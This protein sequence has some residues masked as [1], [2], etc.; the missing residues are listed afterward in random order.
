[1]DEDHNSRVAR[2]EV[3]ELFRRIN[4]PEEY[5]DRFF[6]S[7][8]LDETGQVDYLEVTGIIGPYIQSGYT[9]PTRSLSRGPRSTSAPRIVSEERNKAHELQQLCQI[10]GAKAHQKYRNVTECFR[11]L[12]EDKTGW[13]T[14]AN[15]RRFI[16]IFGFPPSVGDSVF[17]ILLDDG[18]ENPNPDGQVSF[19][20]F[21][22]V[23]GPFVQPGYNQKPVSFQRK[24]APES[25]LTRSQTPPPEE[26]PKAAKG[27]VR[28]QSARYHRHVSRPGAAVQAAAGFKAHTL[29]DVAV[30]DCCD[31]AS[32]ASGSTAS[33]G[34]SSLQSDGGF[35]AEPLDEDGVSVT[36]SDPASVGPQLLRDNVKTRAVVANG[37][38]GNF[39][40]LPEKPK[41]VNHS[42]WDSGKMRKRLG[43]GK[44]DDPNW[45]SQTSR[46][47][48][49]ALKSARGIAK[50][51]PSGF[52][53]TVS[54][55]PRPRAP[56]A[57][58][59][60]GVQ[61]GRRPIQ[62][63]KESWQ[64]RLLQ[65]AQKQQQEVQFADEKPRMVDS[66]GDRSTAP[67][68]P[69]ET[70][71]PAAGAAKERCVNKDHR[72]GMVYN[73]LGTNSTGSLASSL[74]N[75]WSLL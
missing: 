42:T 4:L 23:F 68:T 7:L 21:V 12:D 26:R 71:R 41:V 37:P 34:K 66:W 44:D 50:E 49:Y 22:D 57:P 18:S 75:R 32:F 35:S 24:V 69:H 62:R 19:L 3:Q 65:Q 67:G 47:H 46:V 45:C 70:C 56:S 39:C 54:N 14:R 61:R 53:R 74:E 5:A 27:R 2:S 58:P 20:K 6:D 63:G 43:R 72:G 16:E 17:D 40:Y 36:A 8:E 9:A 55:P 28:P 29:A 64:Q 13:V 11:Y 30:Q 73:A 52:S 48:G 60:K 33:G 31:A 25:F 59:P 1:M 10:I 51:A 38:R 15:C